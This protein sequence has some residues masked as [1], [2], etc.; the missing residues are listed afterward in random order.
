V[1]EN[2]FQEIVKDLDYSKTKKALRPRTFEVEEE[3][4]EEKEKRKRSGAIWLNALSFIEI[5]AYGLILF[6]ISYILFVIFS[7]I[8]INQ[9]DHHNEIILAEEE[10]E[11]IEDMDLVSELDKALST[12]DYRQAVRIRFLNVLQSLSINDLIKWKPEKTNR[13][14]TRELRGQKFFTQFRDLAKVFELVWY[15]NTTISK[16]EYDD[17]AVIFDGFQLKGQ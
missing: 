7:K 9:S 14:Y 12:G 13:D 3:S 2:E 8:K 16:A 6:L 17:I 15:G 5:L 1:G 10:E 4:E 11:N